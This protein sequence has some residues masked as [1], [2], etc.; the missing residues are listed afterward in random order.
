MIF[1]LRL[2]DPTFGKKQQ[3]HRRTPWGQ[4][5]APA[6]LRASL[7]GLFQRDPKDRVR[8]AVTFLAA[9]LAALQPRERI[10]L[11]LKALIGPAA[12]GKTVFV[13]CLSR[14]SSGGPGWSHATLAPTLQALRAKGLLAEDLACAPELLHPLA[15]EAINSAE[16]AVMV[17]AI[18]AKL[19]LDN[20]QGL[21]PQAD[22]GRQPALAA[23]R[24]TRQRR[25][26]VSAGDQLPPPIPLLHG[27]ASI[28]LRAA[29]RRP[30]MSGS[31][32]SLPVAP[33]FRRRCLRPRPTTGLR[34][35]SRRRIT[36][37]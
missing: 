4:V 1:G 35:A 25:G 3:L 8:L 24:R 19:P 21:G 2:V 10:L 31:T 23:P 9:A 11:R 37:R 15:V 26:R 7:P 14:V 27:R 34:P 12:I 20:P 16:G 29:L 13:E 22:R 5:T 6:L 36:R 32:G 33:R 17:E 18:R 30:S 28:D